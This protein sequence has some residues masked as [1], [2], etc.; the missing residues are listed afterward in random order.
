M[1][2]IS[3]LKGFTLIELLLTLLI[4]AILSAMLLPALMQPREK[5]RR[6]NCLSNLKQL[7]LA[8]SMYAQ[9]NG[10]RCPA[11]SSSPTLLGSLQ[12]LSNSIGSVKILWCPSDHH[13]H[14]TAE[15]GFPDLTNNNLSYSY[16]PNLTWG[17][18]PDSIVALDRIYATTSGSQWPISG[19]HGGGGGNVLFG[20]GHVAWQGQLPSALKDKDGRQIVLSP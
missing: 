4:I 18:R 12:L 3:K 17:D 16:V 9:E 1:A 5:A 7:G 6:A 19:N 11:D 8:I 20:D 14:Y 13:I 10:G 2:T 15:P